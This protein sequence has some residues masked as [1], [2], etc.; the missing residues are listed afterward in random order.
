MRLAP[1]PRLKQRADDVRL[2]ELRTS[3]HE[4]GGWFKVAGRFRCEQCGQSV[5]LT[6]SEKVTLLSA[7]TAQLEPSSRLDPPH[8]E[9]VLRRAT[10][11]LDQ[12]E[13]L[14]ENASMRHSE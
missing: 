3:S 2:S 9:N 5:R 4:D 10:F 13:E 7:T 12:V 11:D 14:F 1:L 6:Y 8:T